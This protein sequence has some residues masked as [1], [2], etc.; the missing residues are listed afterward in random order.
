MSI[1]DHLAERRLEASGDTSR[2]GRE[3]R[4][5]F[6]VREL[7]VAENRDELLDARLHDRLVVVAGKD[8][9]EDLLKVRKALERLVAD[10][11]RQAELRKL[12]VER[13][14]VVDATRVVERENAEDVAGSERGSRLLDQ[15]GN[16]V[17]GSNER[18][19][20]LCR[21]TCQT[22]THAAME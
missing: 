19:D 11:V 3:D 20:H 5:G 13:L 9:G 4:A 15:L 6:A 22:H 12:T 14:G 8:V 18:H 16:T 7:R 10:N 1:I 17:F 21:E 2:Q